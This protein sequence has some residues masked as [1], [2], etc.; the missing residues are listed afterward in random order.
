MSGYPN[1]NRWDSIIGEAAREFNVPAWVIKT[2]IAQESSFDPKAYR[3]EPAIND[4]SRGLMQILHRT[5]RAVGY[6][7]DAGNDATHLGGLYMPRAN[8]FAGTRYLATI[9]DRYPSESW[10]AR[11]AAYNS[12]AIRRDQ[13][14]RF[15]NSKGLPN[16]DRNVRLWIEKSARFR[17]QEGLPPLPLSPAPAPA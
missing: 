7:G 12:G 13:A 15:V 8:I 1:E 16:V 14:G 9:R 17:Q 3:A 6:D 2:T 11:Y 4:A 5:A 10:P